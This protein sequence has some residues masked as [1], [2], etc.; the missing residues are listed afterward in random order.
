MADKKETL[1]LEVYNIKSL[2]EVW[3][4][5]SNNG[6]YQVTMFQASDG[7]FLEIF[8]KN[9]H[10]MSPHDI[11]VLEE[12]AEKNIKF[13][14]FTCTIQVKSWCRKNERNCYNS[15]ISPVLVFDFWINSLK[16]K[17]AYGTK[18]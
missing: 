1:A 8:P 2:M 12:I 7:W 9:I 18:D 4:L 5:H 16:W 17:E 10:L 14:T 6:D 3:N 15:V 13:A 11:K